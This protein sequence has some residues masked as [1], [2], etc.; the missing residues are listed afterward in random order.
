[1]SQTINIYSKKDIERFIDEELNKKFHAYN[2]LLNTLHSKV[3]DLDRIIRG[4]K[5][6][7]RKQRKCT[8]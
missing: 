2:V 3:I 8:D 4:L 7:R 5:N 6:D 1:M